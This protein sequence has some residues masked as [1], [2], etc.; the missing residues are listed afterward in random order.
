ML[1]TDEKV[2]IMIERFQTSID[3]IDAE[4]QKYCDLIDL[5]DKVAD[6]VNGHPARTVELLEDLKKKLEYVSTATSMD[7]PEREGSVVHSAVVTPWGLYLT[8]FFC[9]LFGGAL[10]A[11]AIAW[12]FLR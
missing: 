10:G 8:M 12:W 2:N 1:F 4:T 11:G 6:N 3:I 5:I 7:E 9:G